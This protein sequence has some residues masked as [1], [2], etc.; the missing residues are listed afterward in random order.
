MTDPRS[1]VINAFNGR[2]LSDGFKHGRAY[3]VASGNQLTGSASLDGFKDFADNF[4]S[5]TGKSESNPSR[6]A[7]CVFRR[8]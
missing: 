7:N 2:N 1:N 8:T 5:G 3:G 4:D 6:I